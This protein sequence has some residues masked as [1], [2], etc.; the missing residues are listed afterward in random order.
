MCSTINYFKDLQIRK[1]ARMNEAKIENQ[2]GRKC[3]RLEKEKM[4][5]LKKSTGKVVPMLN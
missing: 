5:K 3:G 1:D 4:K 2:K